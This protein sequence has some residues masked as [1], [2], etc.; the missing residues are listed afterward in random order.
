MHYNLEIRLH[1]I[2]ICLFF[3]TSLA[4]QEAVIPRDSTYQSPDT[5]RSDTLLQEG[6][7][8]SDDAVEYPIVYNAKDTLHM[9]QVNHKV[10]LVNNATATYGDI[11]LEAYYIDLDLATGEVYARGR[12]DSA[13][14]LVD[15]PIFR[16]G[17]EEYES[18]E[19]VYN[20]KS[21]K[22]LIRNIRTEQEGG[23]LNSSITKMQADGSLHA[24]GSQYT[25]CEADHPHFYVSLNKAKVVPGEKII[26]GPAYLV[27]EDIPLPIA[28]PFGYFPVPKKVTSGIIVPRYGEETNR[29][30][31]LK[32]GGYYFAASE[33][34]DLKLTGDIYTNGTWRVATGSN[35]RKRYKFNGNFTF[36]YANNVTGYQGLEDYSKS[37]NYSVR[38]SHS[39]D[40][41]A[42][43]GSRL[44]AS[45]NMSSSG[46]DKENSYQVMEHVTTTKSS[47]ISYSKSWAGT[48]FNFS[49][50]FNHSQ[51]TS[52]QSVSVN[53]PKMTFSA[54]RIYPLKSNKGG[55]TTKWWQDLQ[56]QYTANLDNRINTVDSLLF[57][58][59]VWNNMDNGFR[60]EIPVSIPIR[61]FNNFSISP[62]LNYSGVLYT[63]MTQKTWVEDYYDPEKNDTVSKVVEEQLSGLFYGQAL[64]PRISASF[65][66]QLFGTYTFKN[67]DARVIAI[68]HVIKPSV[69]F[70]L[71]PALDGLS[72]DMYRT[73]QSDTLGNTEEYSI[74]SKGIYGTPTTPGRS[75]SLTFS[76]VN[77]IEGKVRTRNDTTGKGEKVKLIDNLG[78]NTS[79]N[80]FADSLRW[81]PIRMT[82]RTR[83]AKEIDF[84]ASGSFDPYATDSLYRRINTSEF[85]MNHNLARL[86]AF[87]V[88]VGFDLGRLIDNFTGR[89]G[90]DRGN[91][92]T[93]PSG[94]DEIGM[95]DNL[96]GGSEDDIIGGDMGRPT[97]TGGLIFD[98]Y[99]YSNFDMPWSLR[100]AYTFYYSKPR[101][102]SVIKQ[103][104]TVSGDVKLTAKTS[105]RYTS[106]YDIS[107][108]EITMTSIGIVRDLHCWEMSFN[109]VPIGYLQ[110]WDFTIRI[111]ASV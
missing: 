81:S 53:L 75:G 14:N 102:E 9:D 104:F 35:Y 51:N 62:Q 4:G 111:K 101:D 2:I 15:T 86:T 57:T 88:S 48:P 40:A 17:D 78:F 89:S 41:K 103:N 29:G 43:P 71:V 82:M 80:I 3:L 60:H 65:S 44:S 67:Q 49:T 61:P 12:L 83:L 46:Y 21:K 11:Y 28:L 34:F 39:Q 42:R 106:G 16:D 59:E 10:H 95:R 109:W 68:R 58:P 50:S 25:T 73:V 23:F 108:K 77:I 55:G 38:W 8:I 13:G 22:A 69:G 70:S 110:S 93:D 18:K 105:L 100:F 98:R 84:S 36:T 26:S 6:V 85:K 5:L 1:L 87:N 92:P 19:I 56:L 97:T 47:S 63:E 64:S 54:S 90:Q 52:N 107:S 30:Y 20:F 91:I 24:G 76:L 7:K 45:V 31:Y 33:Y 37:S 32:D 72:S 79:Y 27:L 66:P 96:S 74:F 99:G 94:L